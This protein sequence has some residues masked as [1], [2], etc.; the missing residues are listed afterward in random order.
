[1]YSDSDEENHLSVKRQTE[2][3]APTEEEAKLE[4]EIDI[5]DE[6]KENTKKVT[7][8]LET[9]ANAEKTTFEEFQFEKD[10]QKMIFEIFQ[11]MVEEEIAEKVAEELVDKSLK[12]LSIENIFKTPSKEALIFKEA[13]PSEWERVAHINDS[14]AMSLPIKLPRGNQTKIDDESLNAHRESD[15]Q[16]IYDSPVDFIPLP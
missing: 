7:E 13:T 5:V 4:K 6:V 11:K 9:K 16:S 10:T 14:F 3:V 1:M 2:E 15:E 8:E 12:G